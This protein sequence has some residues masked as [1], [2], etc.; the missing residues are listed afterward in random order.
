MATQLNGLEGFRRGYRGQRVRAAFLKLILSASSFALGSGRT[1]ACALPADTTALPGTTSLTVEQCVALARERAPDVTAAAALRL[2]ARLDSVATW[3]NRR[4][5]F[6]LSGGAAVAPKGFYDPV[7]TNLGDYQ[8]TLGMDW[9]LL[10]RGTRARERARAALETA[11]ATSDLALTARDAGRRAA[12][13]ALDLLRQEENERYQADAALWL[14]RLSSAVESGVRSGA[15]GRADALR[16]GLE[17]STA[18][19]A[20]VDTRRAR[21]ELDRE[22]AELIGGVEERTVRVLE[23]DAAAEAPL[24]AADSARLLARAAELPAVRAAEI[25]EA[26][27]RLAVREAQRK[28]ALEV[29]FAAD[30]GLKGADLTR[31]VPED[32]RLSDP[33]ATFSDRVKRDLG[34]SVSLNFRRPILDRARSAMVAAREEALKAASLRRRTAALRARR[35]ALDLTGRWRAASE[36]V[37]IERT[38]AGKGEENLVRMRSLYAG[39]GAGLLEVLDARR[40]LDE[41]RSRLTEARFEARRA[42]YEARIP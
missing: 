38:A 28:N 20:L 8:L 42:Y 2:S 37:A 12:T 30:A 6:A 35:D 32:M 23:P 18:A 13:V 5:S 29:G 9:P 40:Q 11:S 7:I 31:L 17:H 24:A 39:G 16:A 26:R 4:P 21:A 22:L 33:G 19:A 34:A 3:Y 10:D 15:H 27:M 14:E 25:E 36:R 41:A 1:V